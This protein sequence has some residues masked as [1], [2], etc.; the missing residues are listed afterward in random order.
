MN[1]L[2]AVTTNHQNTTIISGHG[3]AA[4]VPHST[5]ARI[6]SSITP[7]RIGCAFHVMTN[8]QLERRGIVLDETPNTLIV[9]FVD[10]WG[11]PHGEMKIVYKKRTES[12][13]WFV[14][15]E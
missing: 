5:L 10:V 6:F 8:G 7:S 11:L 3:P 4:P 1:N 14:D 9:Q 2:P 13:K 12:W 15:V